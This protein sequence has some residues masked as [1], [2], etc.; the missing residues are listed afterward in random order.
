MKKL[1]ILTAALAAT[2]VFADMKIGTV[3]MF[4]LV[5]NHSSY[6]SNR[7]FLVE[8]E[9]DYAR[10]IDQM[11]ADLETVQEEGKK[12]TEQLRNPMLA[13]AAKAKI[14]KQL[15]DIQNRFLSGQQRIRSEAMR[16][17]QDLQ[18]HEARLLK[19][20][21]EDLR[22]KIA[23]YAAENGYDL[24]LDERGVPFRKPS[25][26]VTAGVLTAMGVDP[27]KGKEASDEGK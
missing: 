19:A 7:K 23:A 21:T 2:T 20:T 9:K 17:Q 1:V 27:D 24:I 22:A 6:E 3:D 13:A 10:K 4:K 18:G 5:R 25:L 15:V 11:K 26:D 8:T 12:L 14:E 16:S